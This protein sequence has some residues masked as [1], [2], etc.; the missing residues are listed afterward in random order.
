[1]LASLR[2]SAVCL[3]CHVF[4]RLFPPAMRPRW[5]RPMCEGAAPRAAWAPTQA[6]GPAQPV[7]FKCK[8]VDTGHKSGEYKVRER[9]CCLV[10]TF[11]SR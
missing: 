6:S 2:A 3:V 1:M 8:I 9:P 11:S 10:D 5:V 7:P 4:F